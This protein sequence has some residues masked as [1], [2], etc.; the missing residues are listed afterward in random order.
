M[1]AKYPGEAHQVT[2]WKI[3]QRVEHFFISVA[4]DVIV[5]TLLL[6]LVRRQQR[7][8]SAS[9][10]RYRALF[11][12]ANDGI[13]VLTETDQRLVEVNAR[14]V[15]IFGYDAPELIG[16][17]VR[18]LQC[19]TGAKLDNVPCDALSTLLA[20]TASGECEFMIRTST[21]HL[22]PV[23]VS[24]SRLTADGEKLINLIVRDL[25]E[26]RRLEAEKETMQAQLVHDEKITALGQMAAQVTHEVKNPLAGLRLYTL[27]LKSKVSGKLAAS[28]ISLIDK[29]SLT[30][31]HLAATT[32][33]ILN[34]TR[35]F[36]LRL[37]S[38]DLN[39]LVNDTLHLL[40]PQL[41]AGQVEVR[42]HLSSTPMLGLI[43]EA[44]MGSALFNLL[45][46]SVQ[47]MSANDEG[48][49]LTLASHVDD[50]SLRLSIEDTGC[51]MNEE[52]I[53]KVFEPFYTTKSKGFGLGM[54]YVK[55]VIEA[56]HGSIL[57]ESRHGV[58]TSITVKLPVAGD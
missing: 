54:P 16:R 7:K 22:R 50:D 3:E 49:T 18:E 55:R 32:E 23:L 15:E 48:G 53:K 25:S 33:Q 37:Q 30:I 8:L 24:F 34:F 5:V 56:H 35:P 44:S 12:H 41:T 14:F 40:E 6:R 4:V 39:K 17:S 27:H 58:G 28:E 31:D 10:E 51:G 38:I 42:L 1:N 36:T 2:R 46:N 43:D 11:E 57:I 47:A 45:L 20:T 21:G 9:E 26:R 19:D 29:I 13:G 52:Q